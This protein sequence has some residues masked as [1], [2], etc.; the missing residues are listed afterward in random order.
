MVS[1]PNL[2]PK[3][4][5]PSVA[6]YEQVFEVSAAKGE[7]VQCLCITTKFS[8]S[9]QSA[10]IAKDLI[11]EKYPEADICVID[12]MCNTVLQ[13][14]VVAEACNL[15]D[16]GYSLDD[17]VNKLYEILDTGRIFF[18]IGSIEYL[19]IGGR[20]GKLAGK[21]SAVLGIRP[22]ITLSDGEIHSSGICRGRLKSVDK[23]LNVAKEYLRSN[24]K[25]PDEL[26]I[27]IGYGYNYDEALTFRGRVHALLDELSLRVDVP[28]YRIGAVI[29]VH[30]GPFPLG[31]GV[32]RKATNPS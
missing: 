8:A 10:S 15:R 18:T 24:F 20:I 19:S 21:V 27:S 1:N 3:S 5:A 2:F 30:T 26:S 12:T 22:I 11:L 9:Y 14:L 28:I 23:V 16:L 17:A 29:G 13:G 4:A 25:S 31:I 6:D 32:L 7:K